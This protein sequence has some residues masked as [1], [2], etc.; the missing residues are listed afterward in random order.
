MSAWVVVT[1]EDRSGC[2]VA[3]FHRAY[4]CAEYLS[5]QR[6]DQLDVLRVYAYTE[7][8]SRVRTGA[9]LRRD[10]AAREFLAV[11]R[12]RT[13]FILATAKARGI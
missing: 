9:D 12:P 2:V 6:D 13:K 4:M 11:H 5:M 1:D 3:A 7:W 8:R 10:W